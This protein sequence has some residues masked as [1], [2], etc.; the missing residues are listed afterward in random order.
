MR[1]AKNAE[2]HHLRERAAVFKRGARRLAVRP[3]LAR[4]DPV[5]LVAF[6]H[7]AQRL[8]RP[9]V[10]LHARL[11]DQAHLVGPVRCVEDGFLVT[12]QQRAARAD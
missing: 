7:A 1:M 3:V 6:D 4:A 8:R 12:D 11:G 10:L 2:Q 9:L 5:A